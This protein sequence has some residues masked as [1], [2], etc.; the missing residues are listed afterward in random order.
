M[1]LRHM[2]MHEVGS[3]SVGSSCWKG[4]K[5]CTGSGGPLGGSTT[6]TGVGV[7][8]VSHS[9]GEP[10]AGTVFW[11][12][13]LGS[14]WYGPRLWKRARRVKEHPILTSKHLSSHKLAIHGTCI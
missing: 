4:H 2:T 6:A 9:V 12:Q 13:D 5:G 3:S 10:Q 7:H 11:P 8:T 1:P 14:L